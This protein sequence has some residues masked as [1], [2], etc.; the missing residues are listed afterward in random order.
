M[1]LWLLALTLPAAADSLA[2]HVVVLSVDDGYRSV[3]E[4][5]YPLL[6]R[7]GM[8]I[9]LG[10]IA[11]NVTGQSSGYRPGA[12]FMTRAEIQEMID[13]CAIE[14]ASHTLSHP[15]LT[16]LTSEAALR[17]ISQSKLVLESLFNRP[18]VT[19]V[20]PYGDMNHSIR[21]MVRQA[22]Y[23]LGRAVRPGPV[24]IWAD[25]YRIPEFE[26]RRETS[27]E[28]A[29]AHIRAHRL[30]VIL[31]HRIVERP[32]VFTEWP[33]ADFARLLEWLDRNGAKT[34]TLGDIYYEYWR[35]E[36]VKKM[37]A[38]AEPARPDPLFQQVDVDATKTPHTR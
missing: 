23:K 13:S 26:L 37:I 12:T 6:K 31:L 34:A 17:E 35:R 30:A 11:D 5:I 1:L 15:W 28:A 21:E 7:Y 33:R 4:N 27:L 25:P 3:Y 24:D 32:T 19:F 10:V 16:R 14:V 38:A 2:G 36:L 22:G 8:T 20:Y 29:M 18:V 9:T